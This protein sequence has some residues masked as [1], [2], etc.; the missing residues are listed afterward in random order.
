MERQ[1]ACNELAKLKLIDSPPKPRLPMYPENFLR[2]TCW[3]EL[4]FF[5]FRSCD[6]ADILVPDVGLWSQM[7]HQ[8]Y[9]KNTKL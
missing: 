9:E 4:D 8:N 2:A 6:K 3:M 5:F 7:T 1:Q